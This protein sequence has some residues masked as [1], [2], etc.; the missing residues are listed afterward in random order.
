M[1]VDGFA[2]IVLVPFLPHIQADLI[3]NRLV[4]CAIAVELLHIQYLG[5]DAPHRHHVLVGAMRRREVQ[6]KHV[7]ALN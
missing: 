2:A 1:I 4:G 5:N 6:L 3:D 7:Q